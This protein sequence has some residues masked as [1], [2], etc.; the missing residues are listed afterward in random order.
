MQS[1]LKRRNFLEEYGI[2]WEKFYSHSACIYYETV[3]LWHK[4]MYIL[5]NGVPV[6]QVHVYI[7]KLCTC[8]TS[9]CIYYETVYLWH[10]CMYILW[11]G[12]PVTQVHVY[13]MKRCTCDTSACIYYET[14]YLWHK[15]MYILWNGVPVT[16]V[17]VYIMKRCTCDTSACIYYETV[18]LWHKCMYIL[19]NGVPVTQVHVY[20]MKLCTCDAD[21]D[22]LRTEHSTST[23]LA[24]CGIFVLKFACHYTFLGTQF[25]SFP[26]K[27][28]RDVFLLV[29]SSEVLMERRIMKFYKTIKS[30]ICKKMF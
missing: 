13:I 10:K 6:T 26:L 3:Y 1:S 16:Q 15:C 12:V 18:Y 29:H 2:F 21:C 14:V 30:T 22:E 23:F 7:M 4:C 25:T 9:A 27:Q 11:N 24:V 8:D 17:H 5:W 28:A 19:W 20:I